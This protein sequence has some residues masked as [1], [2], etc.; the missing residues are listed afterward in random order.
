M[1]TLIFDCLNIIPI[2]GAPSPLS[3]ISSLVIIIIAKN[4]TDGQLQGFDPCSLG[5][6]GA[7]WRGQSLIMRRYNIDKM[8]PCCDDEDRWYPCNWYQH[9]D[10]YRKI[11]GSMFN[12]AF[13]VLYHELRTHLKIMLK[14]D[15]KQ[16]TDTSLDTPR[17]FSDIDLKH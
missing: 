7:A 17:I 4:A 9:P 10:I 16:F 14:I 5:S 3:P 11:Q 8:M 13:K 1:Y 2:W 15:L 6:N 12:I